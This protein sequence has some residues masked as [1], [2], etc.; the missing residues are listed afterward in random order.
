M[1]YSEKILSLAAQAEKDLAPHFERIDRI[2]FDN[3]QRVMDAFRDFRV[4]D[5]MFGRIQKF[6]SKGVCYLFDRIFL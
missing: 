2:A 1:Q 3:M 5:S 4:S 6:F